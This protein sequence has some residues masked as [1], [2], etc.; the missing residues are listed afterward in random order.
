MI[1]DKCGY[2]MGAFDTTCPRCQGKGGSAQV[3]PVNQ[4]D[5]S[6]PADSQP[7]PPQ[8]YQQ[9]TA[10]QPTATN[11]ATQQQQ[12]AA[13]GGIIGLLFLLYWLF[14]MFSSP[15]SPVSSPLQ[16]V[17][18]KY[19]MSQFNQLSN[20]M[21]Y[22]EATAIMGDGGELSSTNTMPGVEGF[23][24]PITTSMYMWKNSD[25]SNM[26]AMFQNDKLVSKAQFGLK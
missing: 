25:G 15:F 21:S 12:G 24:A 3:P 4:F 20:G 19:S 17:G 9:Q 10:Q 16:Q 6:T 22:S 8:P 1:C 23:S 26:N 13:I 2:A 14:N 11:G 18:D 7:L 5:L